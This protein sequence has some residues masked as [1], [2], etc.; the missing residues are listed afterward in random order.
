VH[1]CAGRP[2]CKSSAA[3]FIQTPWCI[4]FCHSLKAAIMSS[5]NPL[6][7]RGLCGN[8]AHSTYRNVIPSEC[9]P[10]LA[11]PPGLWVIIPFR[12]E[13]LIGQPSDNRRADLFSEQLAQS[14][15]RLSATMISTSRVLPLRCAPN[16]RSLIDTRDTCAV[17]KSHSGSNKES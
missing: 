4:R 9:N 2:I 5:L 15:K 8:S 16:G 3:I 10:N 11:D 7:A 17:C 14:M 1:C 12:L 6:H 13:L